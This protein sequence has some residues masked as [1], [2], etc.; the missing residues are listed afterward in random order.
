MAFQTFTTSSVNAL[1]TQIRTRTE[2]A[3][4]TTL[5]DA[6][7]D[8]RELILRSPAGAHVGLRAETAADGSYK[9]LWLQG[10]R[11]FEPE[12]SFHGQFGAIVH[13]GSSAL[14]P[15]MPLQNL[16]LTAWLAISDR[17]LLIVVKLSSVYVAA[18]LGYLLP[19]ASDADY[20]EPLLIGG[21]ITGNAKLWSGTTDNQNIFLFGRGSVGAGAPRVL[22]PNGSWQSVNFSGNAPTNYA[23]IF[24]FNGGLEQLG[25]SFDDSHTMFQALVVSGLPSAE[26]QEWEGEW[27]GYIEGVFGTDAEAVTSESQFTQL[28]RTFIVFPNVF[29]NSNFFV[30]EVA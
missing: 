19:F 13:N 26:S 21:S 23:A 16:P 7:T 22:L 18:H 1:L 14:C 8:E 24:P 4:W 29:R 2:A 15:A 28:S 5:R 9:N 11:S 17:R 27:L 25:R 3:G 20:P 30:L 6:T 12:A 10:Y